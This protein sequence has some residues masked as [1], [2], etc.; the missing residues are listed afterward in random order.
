MQYRLSCAAADQGNGPDSAT[1]A[2]CGPSPRAAQRL[3]CTRL[4]PKA[5]L[6]V[7]FC[8]L[9]RDAQYSGYSA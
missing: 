2:C 4:R 8:A 3:A 5:R 6:C 1:C 7:F 9:Q